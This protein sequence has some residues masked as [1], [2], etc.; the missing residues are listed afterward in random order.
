LLL[1]AFNGDATRILR[2][3]WLIDKSEPLFDEKWTHYCVQIDEGLRK[4]VIKEIRALLVLTDS[5]LRTEPQIQ[6]LA[7]FYAHT[8]GY[9]YRIIDQAAYKHVREDHCLEQE[10]VDFGLYGRRYIYRT[11]S[12][13]KETTGR[14]CKDTA[15]I[16]RYTKFFDI[17]W[18]SHS[19]LEVDK[20]KLSK[21]KLSDVLSLSW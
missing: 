16:D 21:T 18:G 7:G 6:N 19:A 12:Y 15:V 2:Y 14:F 5:S 9:K 11:I 17:V 3:V 8:K 13:G 20:S 1:S 10:Y 4:G